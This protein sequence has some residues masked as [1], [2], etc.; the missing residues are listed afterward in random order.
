MFEYL[1]SEEAL[2]AGKK[3]AMKKAKSGSKKPMKK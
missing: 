1:L 3:K 2:S